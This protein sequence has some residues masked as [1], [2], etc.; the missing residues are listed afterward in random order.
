MSFRG[1]VTADGDMDM[2]GVYELLVAQN[3]GYHANRDMLLAIIAGFGGGDLLLWRV[4]REGD[5]PSYACF[6]QGLNYFFIHAGI[7]NLDQLLGAILGGLCGRTY[8]LGSNVVHAYFFYRFD[9]LERPDVDSVL[10]LAPANANFYIVGHSGGYPTA[11]Y[12]GQYIRSLRPTA[13]VRVL[14]VGGCKAMTAGYRGPGIDSHQRLRHPFDIVPFVPPD[15]IALQ[16]TTGTILEVA[17]YGPLSW[18][19]FGDGWTLDDTGV[20]ASDDEDRPISETPSIKEFLDDPQCH[21]LERYLDNIEKKIRLGV[22]LPAFTLA[23][24]FRVATDA[25]G[26][27]APDPPRVTAE[28]YISV[29]DVGRVLGIP[30]TTG[31]T[32]SIIELAPRIVPA[33]VELVRVLARLAV[34]AGLGGPSASPYAV[35]SLCVQR[36]IVEGSIRDQ[37]IEDIYYLVYAGS[38]VDPDPSD[39]G[40]LLASFQAAYRANVLPLAYDD[41]SVTRYA[42][43]ELFDV[44]KQ[45]DSPPRYS[46]LLDGRKD[47]FIKGDAG[48]V[49]Q[50]VSGAL[51]KLPVHEVLRV[52]MMASSRVPRRFKRSY[53]FFSLGQST[54]DLGVNVEQWSAAFLAASKTA[55]DSMANT[56]YNGVA[57][58]GGAGYRLAVYSGAYWYEEIRPA[59]LNYIALGARTIAMSQPSPYIGSLRSRLY[60]P[61]GVKHGV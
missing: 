17:G 54:Q 55:F 43:T 42:M 34:P 39:S 53:L 4:E 41:Y 51:A 11:L 45:S 6:R 50:R 15:L 24:D 60:S 22:P 9:D 57:T 7:V 37:L 49:G 27:I 35:D 21:S 16:L 8:D 56:T 3:A 1:L 58:P 31:L 29:A 36:L 33:T 14:G 18:R 38:G 20:M 44:T 30:D 61:S 2:Q 40:H 10:T 32:S 46:F 47:D 25:A 52:N 5:M 13:I 28:K 12:L 48:D 26:V 19:H 23:H 59:L